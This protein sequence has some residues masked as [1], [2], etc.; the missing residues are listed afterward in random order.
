MFMT[1]SLAVLVALCYSEA[2]AQPCTDQTMCGKCLQTAGC[3]WCNLTTFDGARCFG[4]NVSSSMG[5]SS[6]VDPRSAPTTTTVPAATDSIYTTTPNVVLRPGDP[7]TVSV[8][9][10]S[11]PNAPLDLY[12]LM[13]LSDSMAAPLATVKSIS[14]LIA[15]QVSS[16]TTNVRIGFG[17]FNDKP[18]YPY[19]PQTPAGCLPGRDAPDCS[20]RRAGT[21]QYSFLHLANFTSNFTVPNVFVTTNLDLPESSFDSLVQVLACEKELGWRNRSVE[22]PERGL[23]RLVL[24]ITD[25]Q[26]HLAGDGRLASIYQPNDGK[27]HV[28]PY[29]SSVGY[30]D[31]AP[32][33]LIYNED[34][35]LYDYPSVGLVASLLKKYDVIPIFGIVPITSSTLLINNTFLSSYQALQDLMTSVGTK[36]FAR[37]I[38]SSAS[39]V[40]D[41]IKTVY[42]EVIQNIAITLPPQSDV[43]VSLSQIT[44]PDG[45]ILVGQT[46]TNVPLSRTTT[47]SVTLTLLNCNTPSS[48][49]LTFSVPGFGTTTISVDKVCSCSCDKNVTVNAQQCNFRG[50]FSCGGCMC[51]AGWTGPACERSK[52]GQPCVNNGTCDSA[53]GMCQCTDY[54][55]GPFSNDSTSG[56]L[57]PPY[58]PKFAGS[59]CSCN[60]FQNCPTNSQNYI[61]SGRGQCACGSCACDAT[62][63]SW[64]WQGKACECPASNYSDCFDT[65]FKSGPLCSGNG[66]CSCDSSG[67]GMCVCSSG[68]TGKYCETKITPT[69]DTIA[70]CIA[71]G[72]CGSLMAADSGQQVVLTCPISSGECTYSYD[73]SP[74]NQVIRMNQVCSFAAWKIIVIV[75][76]GLL[77]LFVVICAIIKIIL[78]ILDYVEVRRWEKELKEADFSKNQNPLYQSPEM[79]YTN[80]AYGKAM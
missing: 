34:S 11:L 37:P 30:L 18:I 57:L 60:N 21:R 32:G 66:M 58:T 70:T 56:I 35:L 80:V 39:D 52:C 8:N 63:Y 12:I 3:V 28:R 55:A 62:P 15:Q 40:L 13:D 1:L 29:A 14:Q 75:I 49:A 71:D 6:I 53:T 76:C 59:T 45:S 50:N 61:C 10:V 31:T 16:I 7:L 23:Q 65:T 68:Y 41:V 74:D 48:S 47:F 64:K 19:S 78:V 67:K 43:A 27:C 44:C 38:S 36:A 22:G 20:D 9:V 79:Q 42:Q 17:A 26:P 77:F 5:C 24:L 46:C 69:C 72:T 2:F 4:R 25:N 73:L 54:T 51:I 33:I